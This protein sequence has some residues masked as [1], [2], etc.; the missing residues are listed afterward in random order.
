[1]YKKKITSF[2]IFLAILVSLGFTQNAYA[3]SNWKLTSEGWTYY[4]NGTMKTR[5]VLT[6]GKWYY[7]NNFGIMEIGWINDNGTWYYLCDTGVM[8]DSKTTTI[9]PDEIKAMYDIIK[10]YS[11]S[12]VLKYSYIYHVS[13]NGYFGELGFSGENLYMFYSEDQYG[14]EIS[15][16][17]YDLSNGNIYELNQGIVTLLCADNKISNIDTSNEVDNINTSITSDEAIKR[18]KTYLADRGKYIPI[19]I[20]YDHDTGNSYVI[21]CYDIVGDNTGTSWYYVDKFT[22]DVTSMF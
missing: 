7:L 14:N 16:Y 8:D 4:E 20:E 1:M 15:Q 3:A 10:A 2:F 11:K 19:K 9:M 21:H 22:G 6:D 12:K 13:Q 5:W 18:V 17:Y